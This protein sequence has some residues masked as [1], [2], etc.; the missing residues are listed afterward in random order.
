M[1]KIKLEYIWLDG[2]TPL[3]GLR[4]KTKIIDGDTATLKLEDLALWGFD[5]SSTQQAEGK[6]SDILLK[7]VALFPDATRKDAFLVMCETLQPSGEPH[8]SN[9]RATIADDPETWFGFEQEYFFWQNG[10]PLG[11]PKDGYPAPQGPY[12]T[13]IGH[14]HVGPIARKLVEEHIDLCEEFGDPLAHPGVL[15]REEVDHA[16]RPDG[17]LRQR[18]RRADRERLEEVFR[19]AQHRAPPPHPLR[20]TNR[21]VARPRR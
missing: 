4:S 11:F 8:P 3:A 2:Y 5:G 16:G 12:Y 14:K 7:P 20:A 9:T 1:A 17:D 13:G 19:T 6:S 21:G 18:H 15:C 10:A